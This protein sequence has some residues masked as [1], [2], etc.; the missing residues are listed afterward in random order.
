MKLDEI[1]SNADG[2]G[3]ELRS[4][5]VDAITQ[6]ITKWN[7][8]R[9]FVLSAPV[10]TGKSMVLRTIQ[11]VYGGNIVTPT[12]QLV[13][14]YVETYPELNKLIGSAHYKC[15][16][17]LTNCGVGA[18]RYNCKGG[19]DSQCCYVKSKEAFLDNKPTLLNTMSAYFNKVRHGIANDINYIDEAHALCSTV[20]SLTST[21]IKFG[22]TER[23]I[24]RKMKID[25]KDLVSEIKLCQF[26]ETKIVKYE[27]LMKKSKDEVDQT[28]YFNVIENT[29]FTF[30][31]LSNNPEV[32]VTNFEE[33]HLRVLPVFAPRKVLEKVLGRTG[34]L[35]TGTFM[36]HDLKE[37]LGDKPF[38][39]YQCDSP[40]PASNRQVIYEPVEC[41]FNYDSI[42]PDLIALKIMEIYKRRNKQPLFVHA[43]YGMAEKLKFYLTEN[44]VL[45]HDKVSKID[46]VE[47]FRQ[48][49]GL[50]IG[51]G[52]AEGLDLSGDVC[53]AQIIIQLS[54]P[55]L[56]DT[57]VKKRKALSDGQDW[58]T[59]ETAKTFLQAIGRT[60]RYPE[61]YSET[62]VLD[63]RFKYSYNNWVRA[64][65]VPKY[66]QDSMRGL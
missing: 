59:A 51:S 49:G 37:L 35:T 40:I 66:V 13:G 30:E 29:K 6:I 46:V 3:R 53:R 22:P 44:D 33:G 57:Y 55:N 50:M 47:E 39:Y 64:G 65:L 45:F 28:K 4:V 61:D 11:R 2:S 42:R 60:S 23:A 34:V 16:E 56:S 15:K 38:E 36:R 8:N 52:L 21:T 17:Y 14:Q 63:S 25:K 19:I 41:N 58:Y 32:F 5:Q 43:T 48:K 1:L 27:A 7:P 31:A 26:L 9:H 54:F 20:R 10:A 12:N 18:A 24:L 62:F